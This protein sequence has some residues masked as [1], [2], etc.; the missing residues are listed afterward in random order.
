M[1][2]SKMKLIIA[3]KFIMSRLINKN[4]KKKIKFLCTLLQIKIN[5]QNN[6][7]VKENIQF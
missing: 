5:F 4:R 6:H 2:I 7:K 1:N 3:N